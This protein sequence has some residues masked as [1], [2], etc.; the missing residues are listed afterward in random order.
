M[1]AGIGPVE[2]VAVDVE[3]AAEIATRNR[4]SAA[5]ITCRGPSARLSSQENGSHS[6]MRIHADL[7]IEHD[8]HRRL[9]AVGEIERQSRRI[10]SSPGSRGNS[11]T[12]LVSPCEA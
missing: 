1:R 8:E 7:E 3:I 11:S 9:Q 12:C 10:R 6:Q 4:E 5:V 2:S